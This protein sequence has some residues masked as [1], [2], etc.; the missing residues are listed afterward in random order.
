MLYSVA[1]TFVAYETVAVV[2][3]CVIVEEFDVRERKVSH[4][5][6][7]LALPLAVYVHFGHF[8]NVA[9]FQFESGLV[10]GVGDAGLLDASVSWK[11][12]LKT[13]RLVSRC[14]H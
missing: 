11:F 6:F 8:N 5:L 10:V 13:K 12:S 3:V 2:F 1:L 7:E 9:Y 4:L 14:P